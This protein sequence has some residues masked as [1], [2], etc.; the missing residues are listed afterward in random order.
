[1]FPF[2]LSIIMFISSYIVVIVTYLFLNYIQEEKYKKNSIIFG[3]LSFF[4]L[5]VYIFLTPLY[6]KAANPN[7]LIYTFVYHSLVLVL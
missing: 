3:Q 2:M 5:I 7:E 4:S 1:M 6:L